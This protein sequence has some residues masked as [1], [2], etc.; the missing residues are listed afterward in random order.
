VFASATTVCNPGSGDV[1]DPDESCPGTPGGACPADVIASA[2]TICRAGSGDICDPDES[3]T[4]VADATCPPD[5]VEPPTTVCRPDAGV[6]DVEDYCPGTPGDPCGPDVKEA[7]AFVTDSGLCPFDV[8]PDK[9]LCLDANGVPTTDPPTA[10]DLSDGSPGCSVGTCQ[11]SGE[12]RLVLTPDGKIWPGYKL[13][14]SN[15][16]Q[17]FYNSIVEGDPGETVAVDINIPYPFVTQGATPVHVYDAQDVYFDQYGCFVPMDA[18]Q[19]IGQTI[20]IEDYMI[21]ATPG[22]GSTLSC[23]SL[24]GCGLDGSGTCSFSVDVGIPGSGQAYVN[25]HL[26]YGLKGA[27]LDVNDGAVVGG[28][29]P[30]CDSNPDRYDKGAAGTVFGTPAVYPGG[31]EALK[32]NTVD[33]AISNCKSYPFSHACTGPFCIDDGTLF[34]DQVQSLNIFKRINGAYG[35]AMAS[36]T[37]SAATSAWVELV[38]VS[39]GELVGSALTDEDGYFAIPYKHKG[40]R[41]MYDVTLIGGSNITQRVQLKANGWAEVNFDVFT[42]TSTGEFNSDPNGGGGRGGPGDCT[43]TE[44]P[45]LSCSDGVDNDCDG[46]TDMRDTYCNGGVCTDGQLG[47][48]CTADSDCCSNKCR[49]PAGRKVCK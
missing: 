37:E 13:N 15:P 46:A 36:D 23:D 4:G 16:G 41:A 20:A 5:F 3:C 7:C 33:V 32:D 34:G 43:V 26:D 47:D 39:T 11:E 2:T 18:L 49:G 14:A 1:C 12:F 21:G 10:C 29:P 45:E 17:Y 28:N 30:V 9:G 44:T 42:G 8:N 25:V 22:G 38:R 31:W 24:A 6:C 48:S 40:K 19:S 35:T 27:S